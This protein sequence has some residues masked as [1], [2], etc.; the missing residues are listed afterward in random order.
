MNAPVD[1]AQHRAEANSK[2]GI[3]DCDVHPYP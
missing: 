3:I 2:Y 1:V